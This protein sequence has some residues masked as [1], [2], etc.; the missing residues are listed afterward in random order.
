MPVRRPLASTDETSA[1]C[2]HLADRFD[3]FHVVTWAE[4]E[5]VDA[6]VPSLTTNQ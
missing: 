5:Q 2:S 1:W 3:V 6:R 4:D